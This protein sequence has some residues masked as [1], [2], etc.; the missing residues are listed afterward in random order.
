ML[1]GGTMGSVSPRCERRVA[2]VILRDLP[3]RIGA[4]VS[5]DMREA[6]SAM[7]RERRVANGW[8]GG[9]EHP[10][11]DRS[12]RRRRIPCP[13]RARARLLHVPQRGTGRLLGPEER[14][15]T[16]L[17]SSVRVSG[18]EVGTWRG[19][20]SRVTERWC[21]KRSSKFL[22]ADPASRG[23]SVSRELARGTEK[24]IGGRYR[25]MFH[26]SGLLRQ[27]SS[28]PAAAFAR[29]EE[30]VSSQIHGGWTRAQRLER[31]FKNDAFMTT[32][33]G[34]VDVEIYLELDSDSMSHTT[35]H[36]DLPTHY[37]AAIRTLLRYAIVMSF[38]G[39]LVGIAFQESAKKLPFSVAP[40]GV[41]AESILQLALVHGHV[42]TLGVLLPL[43]LAG[44]LVLARQVGGRDLGPRGIAFLVRGYLPFAAASLLLQLYKGYHFLLLARSGERNFAVIDEAFLGGSHVV[45]YL[46]YAVVHTGMGVTLGAFLV[47]LW[48]SLRRVS[49]VTQ[50]VLGVVTLGFDGAL[51]LLL[52]T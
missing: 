22:S 52:G 24:K 23:A 20:W 5:A 44:A 6:R 19:V 42:F 51:W 9:T 12:I 31:S 16:L 27:R 34:G 1:P 3:A 38:F 18:A 41:H 50:I 8:T 25:A 48:R 47:A 46:V 37:R 10:S 39:L 49:S 4:V 33:G 29:A 11:C 36:T 14:A 7:G 45:R 17:S 21:E 28:D 43:V 13:L 2:L 35:S 40:A 32:V 15:Q 30:H 26:G